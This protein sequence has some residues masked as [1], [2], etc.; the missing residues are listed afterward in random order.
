MTRYQG[1]AFRAHSPEW[2]SD[3]TSGVGASLHGGRFNKVGVPA[4]YL[5]LT[6]EGALREANNPGFEYKLQPTTLV[7]YEIDCDH[8][9]DLTNA[10][11]RKRWRA[12]LDVLN[13]PHDKLAA[14]KLPVPSWELSERIRAEHHAGI[15]VRSFAWK[16]TSK[17]VN[18]V[19][20]DWGPDL[21]HRVVAID[22]HD[23]LQ[24]IQRVKVKKAKP[25]RSGGRR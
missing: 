24:S 13:C 20:W 11:E 5:A 8:I 7:Q 22:D 23:K 3:P 15:L 12:T 10:D 4:L 19:L 25:K 2:A 9:V 1:K 17:E 6:P 18:L 21:P 16:A 14:L